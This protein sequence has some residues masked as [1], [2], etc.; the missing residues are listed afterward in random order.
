MEEKIRRIRRAYR[1]ADGRTK[2]AIFSL[3]LN[4]LSAAG[5]D[6]VMRFT[7]GII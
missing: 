2:S 1:K 5:I 7:E 3:C 6:A 4:H